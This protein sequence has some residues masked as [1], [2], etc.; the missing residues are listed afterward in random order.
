MIASLSGL[1][2]LHF[3]LTKI[4]FS[5]LGGVEQRTFQDQFTNGLYTGSPRVGESLGNW[6]G[7]E[8]NGVFSYEDFDESGNNINTAYG[9][10]FICESRF[11]T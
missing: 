8:T 1:Q 11:N 7:Y 4:R 9:T 6:I 10:P 5:I 2:T 3:Q